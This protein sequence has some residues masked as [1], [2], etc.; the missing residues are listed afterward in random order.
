MKEEQNT[1]KTRIGSM[2]I[3]VIYVG[4]LIKISVDNANIDYG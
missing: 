1:H 4:G 2:E 3:E